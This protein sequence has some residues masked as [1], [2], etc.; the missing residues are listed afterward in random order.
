[1]DENGMMG[2]NA[3]WSQDGVVSVSGNDVDPENE[4][5]RLE[6]RHLAGYLL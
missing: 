2:V 5:F 1:M 4:V 3:G 6:M